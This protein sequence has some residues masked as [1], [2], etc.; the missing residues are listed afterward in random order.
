M[1]SNPINCEWIACARSRPREQ[2]RHA[3]EF[4]PSVKTVYGAAG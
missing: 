1:K 2:A 4:Q 3:A